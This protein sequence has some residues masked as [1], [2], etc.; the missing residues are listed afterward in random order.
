M[1]ASHPDHVDRIQEQWRRER[2]D[3][4][5]TPQAMRAV[6]N[7]QVGA[8]Y[9]LEYRD[10]VETVQLAWQGL[11]RQLW[12]FASPGGR[13]VLVQKQR[14]AAF[15]QAGLLVPAQDEALTVAATRDALAKINADP[16]RLLDLEGN[17]LRT[18]RKVSFC[19]LDNIRWDR[20][21]SPRRRYT[22]SSQGIQAGWGDVYDS[23]LAGQW[24]EIGDLP[25]GDYQLEL[26]VNPDNILPETNYD[27]NVVRIPVTIPAE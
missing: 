26:T 20:G 11:R 17:E 27:N 19:L 14:L 10:R 15:L 3:L 16:S 7:L 5:P 22:C 13:C 9:R 6:E 4:D 21:V 1:P 8:W 12:L 18:G 25:A 23:G 2:P 24:I